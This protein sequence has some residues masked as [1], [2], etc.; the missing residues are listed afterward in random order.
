[1]DYTEIK[2]NIRED[3][4]ATM[5]LNRPERLNSFSRR[6]F[7]EWRDVVAHCAFSDD[8]RA[9]RHRRRPFVFIRCRPD[10]SGQ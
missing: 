5:T 4:I 8:I 3:G 1:M 6:M 9:D 10:G 2:F 7:D